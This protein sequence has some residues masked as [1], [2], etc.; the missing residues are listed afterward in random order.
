MR[1]VMHLLVEGVQNV[2]PLTLSCVR[3]VVWSEG[4]EH[5]ALSL[6]DCGGCVHGVSVRVHG[7]SRLTH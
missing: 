6:V 7:V 3:D 4:S 5:C 1:C 2:G